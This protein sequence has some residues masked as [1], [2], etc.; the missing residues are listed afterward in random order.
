M[1]EVM[2]PFRWNGAKNIQLQ[3]ER[4]I[5]FETVL[6]SINEGKVLATIQHPNL[7]KYPS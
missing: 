2:K 7:E 3:A 4:G 1:S 5:N 6:Q